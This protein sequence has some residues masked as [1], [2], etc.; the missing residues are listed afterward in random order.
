MLLNLL[1]IG[2]I[3]VHTPA[4]NISALVFYYASNL[5]IYIL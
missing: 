4:Q 1:N 3:N 2:H 5:Y